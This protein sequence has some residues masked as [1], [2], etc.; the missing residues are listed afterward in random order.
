MVQSSLNYGWM[1]CQFQCFSPSCSSIPPAAFH[2][3]L[4]ILQPSRAIFFFRGPC[5]K[6]KLPQL[7]PLH[8]TKQKR[9]CMSKRNFDCHFVSFHFAAI[10]FGYH[11]EIEVKQPLCMW[12]ISLLR[13]CT[14]PDIPH[15]FQT[16]VSVNPFLP[17]PK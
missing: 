11:S 5:R 16:R 2:T 7:A 1:G 6:G 8:C 4:R 12:Y 13:N 10:F 9:F 14:Q 3:I 15:C 17:A